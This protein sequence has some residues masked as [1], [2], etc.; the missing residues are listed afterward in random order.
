MFDRDRWQEIY[1]TLKSN[2]LR[3]FMTAFGVFWGI[4]MLIIMAGSGNGLKNAVFDGFQDFAT[5]SAFIWTRQTTMPYKG[6]PRGRRW[7][8]NNSD[9]KA[10][11]ESIPEI[12]YLAPRLQP[13][14]GNGDNNVVRGTKTAS[15]DIFG[16]YPDYFRIDPVI[17][18]SGRVINDLDILEKRKVAVIGNRVKEELFNKGEDPIGKYIRIRGVYFQVV[19]VYEPKNKNIS[20][21]EDKEKTIFLP[22]T[23]LQIAYNMGDDVHFIAVTAKDGI[24]VSVVEK[25]VLAMLAARNKVAP[26][27]EQAFGHFNLEEEFKQMNGLFAG[28]NILIWIVGIG[29]LFAGVIG[30][31]NIMLIVVKERTKEI[32]IQRSIGATPWKIIGQILMESVTLTA[33]SGMIGLVLGVGILELINYQMVSSGAEAEMFKNPGVNFDIAVTALTVLIGA[34]LFAGFIPARKAVR[35]KPVEALRAE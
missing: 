23:S 28:I 16:D 34:G 21:G 5:N 14:S 15:Y 19:G 25:K 35:I 9:M 24:E 10:L 30:V 31:S 6:L 7:L 13:W 3:T 32:G 12:G 33:V 18:L 26:E 1:S 2:K 11:K 29:T 4:L 8:F 27:D 20:F 22:F 17:L